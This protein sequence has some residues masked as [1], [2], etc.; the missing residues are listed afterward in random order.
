MSSSPAAAPYNTPPAL[1]AFTLTVLVLCFVAFSIV[2]MCKYCFSSVIHTWA[3]QRTPSGSLIRLTPHRS[4]PRGLDPDLLQVFP[5]FPYSSVKDLRKDQK[6]GLECAICLLEFEDDNVL[7]LLTLCCHV[8]HQDCID[9]WLRSHK[10]CPVCRRDLDSPPPDETQK[11]NEGVVVMSTS[12]E[13]RIDVTEGQDCGG[14]DDNDGNP[15]QEHEREHEHEHGYGNHE[16]MIHQQGE[17]MFARSHS[18]G[19]SIVLIRGEGDEGK[20]DDKYTLRLPEH[21]L[22]VRHN[23]KHN[24]TRSCAS[25]KDIAKLVAPPAAAAPCSNCGFVQPV[26][27]SS[28]S[29][30]DHTRK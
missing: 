22:R 3:F 14:G 30:P 13:I 29:S 17:Q 1:I 19:H 7:R 6:Y 11:A 24:C 21:V 16:V 18:T 26:P 8:F 12:G 25:Y 10:T 23:N 27:P 4:P 20:D 15:R 2:Y 5:T 28:T 9:L